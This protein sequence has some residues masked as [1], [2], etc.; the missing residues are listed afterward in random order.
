M[1]IV[2]GIESWNN[3]E[4]KRVQY[5]YKEHIHYGRTGALYRDPK[6]YEDP[7]PSSPTL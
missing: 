7:F 5:P 4:F 1:T 3:N 6:L 2:L